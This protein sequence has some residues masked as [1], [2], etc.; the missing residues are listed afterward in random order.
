VERL[1]ERKSKNY[2]SNL[3]NQDGMNRGI[4]PGDQASW[5]INVSQDSNIFSRYDTLMEYRLFF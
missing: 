1:F 2:P 4:D 3:I 5:S